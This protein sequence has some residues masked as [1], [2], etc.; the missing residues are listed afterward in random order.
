MD[1]LDITVFVNTYWEALAWAFSALAVIIVGFKIS[2]TEIEED[3]TETVAVLPTNQVAQPKQDF[4]TLTEMLTIFD[5]IIKYKATNHLNK[6]KI[7]TIGG[8][9][10]TKL[11]QMFVVDIKLTLSDR[12]TEKLH[13]IYNPE[14]LDLIIRQKFQ[15]IIYEVDQKTTD[16]FDRRVILDEKTR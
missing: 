14:T 7:D 15:N 2:R 5:S 4:Q 16:K 10:L 6:I 1:I 9:N 3:V 8:D 11:I 13:T 12:F